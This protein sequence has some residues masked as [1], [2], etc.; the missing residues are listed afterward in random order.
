MIEQTVVIALHCREFFRAAGAGV[1]TVVALRALSQLQKWETTHRHAASPKR[2]PMSVAR[3][4]VGISAN[5][6]I[7]GARDRARTSTFPLD[8]HP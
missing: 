8:I 2:G 6:A 1:F 3:R 4:D 5:V 7:A